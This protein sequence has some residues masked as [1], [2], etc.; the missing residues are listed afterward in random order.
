MPAPTTDHGPGVARARGRARLTALPP[1]ARGPGR[2]TPPGGPEVAGPRF[3]KLIALGIAVVGVGAA[4]FI[5]HGAADQSPYAQTGPSRVMPKP[6][7]LSE[8]IADVMNFAPSGTGSSGLIVT[9]GVPVRAALEQATGPA[10]ALARNGPAA[11]AYA[12]ATAVRLKNGT[13]DVSFTVPV[14][15]G[16]LES[17]GYVAGPGTDVAA[18][19]LRVS[20]DGRVVY[21]IR[22]NPKTYRA[23]FRFALSATGQTLTSLN[24]NAM[25]LITQTDSSDT[26]GF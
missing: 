21:A 20:Y 9:P 11:V 7:S 13:Y 6:R 24:F 10:E 14:Q 4:L 15:V 26:L 2:T 8:A 12:H 25:A 18:G 23:V 19:D 17:H 1:S 16:Y 5:A 3:G 22:M